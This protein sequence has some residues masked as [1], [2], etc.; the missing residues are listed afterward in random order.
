MTSLVQL[1]PQYFPMVSVST[2]V[3]AGSLYIGDVDT[4]PTIVGNQKTISALKE[5]GS[6]V[7]ITQPVTLSAG[8]IPLYNGSPVS[9][10]VAGNYSTTILDINGA[11]IYYVPSFFRI[12]GDPLTP[13]NY[14]YPDYSEADQGVTGLGETIKA[15]VDAIGT[16]NK[17]TIYFR[18]NSGNEFTTYTLTT[19]EIPPDNIAFQFEPGAI[20]DAIGDFTGTGG[21]IIAG[22]KQQ[23]FTDTSAILGTWDV[24]EITPEMFGAVGNGTAAPPTDDNVALASSL[25]LAIST[26]TEWFLDKLYYTTVGLS[27]N[28]N[29]FRIKGRHF[30][31]TGI[32][33]DQAIDILTF[34]ATGKQSNVEDILIDGGFHQNAGVRIATSGI[35]TTDCSFVNFTNVEIWYCNGYAWH[36]DGAQDIKHLNCH[37]RHSGIDTTH[38]AIY[39][40]GLSRASNS[41]NFID[42][43]IERFYGHAIHLDRVDQVKI[44]GNKIHGRTPTDPAPVDSLSHGIHIT[45]SKR[46]V[47]ADTGFMLNH[48]YS[49]FG[50]E[51]AGGH[52][53]SVLIH[54]CSFNNVY[55]PSAGAADIAHNIHVDY[56]RWSVLGNN[57]FFVGSGDFDANELASY[58]DNGGD[59]YFGAN[60]TKEDCISRYNIHG[61]D[62]AF[63]F[64]Y[65]PDLSNNDGP[66][67]NF[68]GPGNTYMHRTTTGKTHTG[69]TDET[70]LKSLTIPANVLQTAKHIELKT[71]GKY[72]G[73][74]G[75][76]TLKLYFGTDSWEIDVAAS[77]NENVFELVV[78]IQM[79]DATNAQQLW[80]RYTEG[81]AGTGMAAVV[82]LDHD[83]SV[84]EDTTADID[85]KIT[86]ELADVDDTIFV[87]QFIVR[88]D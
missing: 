84:A 4:D 45:G 60:V 28:G 65:H 33:T 69:T 78:N 66:F 87:N 58:K 2:S 40:V 83:G 20:L 25:A 64:S 80:W 34:T 67:V 15:F 51:G 56:G 76:K 16:T 36:H 52:A 30:R 49:V 37:A 3:G 53:N 46:T 81:A 55:Y 27:N 24:S 26:Q 39:V 23:I 61:T 7:V 19:A 31:K 41:I 8:G 42:C 10:Y 1:G 88:I 59:V 74:D 57:F 63:E 77:G 32:V 38:A 35:K 22:F 50:T 71:F 86:G 48:Q 43:G 13:G 54:G 11:Q 82:I 73:T 62:C 12:Q 14:Y 21:N 6:L 70:D 79:M 68:F 44:I 72:T 47:I 5:D 9:L 18:H 29:K 17:A 85:I 75:T